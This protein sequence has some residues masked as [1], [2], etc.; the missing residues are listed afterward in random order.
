VREPAGYFTSAELLRLIHF[1]E[2]KIRF[3]SRGKC[4]PSL[5]D[6]LGAKA[7]PG[8]TFPERTPDCYP[9]E[10][11]PVD[12]SR[13]CKSALGT[14]ASTEVKVNLEWMDSPNY[15]TSQVIFQL[16]AKTNHSK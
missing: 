3:D 16:L 1:P 8:L 9:S 13:T 11:V 4:E 14:Q 15:K 5:T 10:V 7:P 12:L 2:F 6:A